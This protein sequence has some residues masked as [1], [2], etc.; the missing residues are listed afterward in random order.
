MKISTIGSDLAAAVLCGLM[1]IFAGAFAQG[2]QEVN[3]ESYRQ[4]ILIK[5]V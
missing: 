4:P 2:A 1:T 5:P 3:L